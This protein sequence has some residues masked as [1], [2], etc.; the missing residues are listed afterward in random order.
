MMLKGQVTILER[1]E[2]AYVSLDAATERGCDPVEP[3]SDGA[4]D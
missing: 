1:A 3:E 2:R 4:H